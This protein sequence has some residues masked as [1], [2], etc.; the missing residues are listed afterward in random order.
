MLRQPG[1]RY[2]VGR[3]RTL[4]KVKS[5]H[6]AEAV[7][8]AHHAGAGKHKGRLGALLVRLA[9]GTE[10]SV[11]TG[12]SDA[13]AREPRRRSAPSSLSATRSC[14]IGGVPRFPSYVGV[15]IDAVV[16]PKVISG[17]L[18]RPAAK[19]KRKSAEVPLSERVVVS[20]A[21][22]DQPKAGT[23]MARHFEFV[24]G[25][26][27]KFWEVSRSGADLTTRW[28]RIGSA[29]QS[30][31]KSLGDEDVAARQMA[32]LIEEKTG[33]GYVEKPMA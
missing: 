10:F 28:G 18:P 1:S 32:E 14:P 27:S 23:K 9:D 11:G 31:T 5:F 7:V 3:S 16:T 15:R 6:D 17:D 19:N 4:L 24:D 2:E 33:E 13:R 20:V 26:S 25:K 30:K 12:F 22:I 8:S 29:G 21:P